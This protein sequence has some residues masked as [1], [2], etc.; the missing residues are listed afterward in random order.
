M[1]TLTRA[2]DQWATR[3]ADQ[4]FG[5]LQ[6]MFDVA[7]NDKITAR[8]Q[9]IKAN[10]LRAVALKSGGI[11]LDFGDNA[12]AGT[13]MTN[14]SFGQ[15]AKIAKAPATFLSSLSPK[16]AA[17]AINES[18][19]QHADA[20]TDE[21]G[22]GR[23]V[24]ISGSDASVRAITSQKYG[25]VFNADLIAEL[26]KLE[27]TTPWQPAPEAFDGSR[28]LY[29]G[30]R[31]M[32]CFMV[33]NERRIFETDKAGG[34]GR[35]FFLRNNEVGN[36]AFDI[37]S[38]LYEYVCGNH[39]VWGAQVVGETRVIHIGGDRFE[40]VMTTLT[41]ELATYA[42]ASAKADEA[43]ILTMRR[44]VIGKDK[45]EVVDTIAKLKIDGLGRVLL[46]QAYDKAE[47]R[48][49]WYG[50]PNTVWGFN[51]ALTEIARDK[52]NADARNLIDVGAG[53]VME[54]MAA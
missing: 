4:R 15:L 18:L 27:A 32:F 10:A 11:G 50:A 7:Q 5:S 26:M 43:K 33:D 28:G 35:G 49:D 53:K 20:F 31:D 29:L 24:L 46:G 22:S 3:P 16:I 34:L 39:R 51:G 1:V 9:D 36:G 21:D 40:K 42:N 25:R 6:A 41:G 54:L 12:T 48:V 38:F 23:Q 45:A 52:T 44:K 17:A 19:A 2:N 30:D 8:V 47:E 37:L 14:W 13:A